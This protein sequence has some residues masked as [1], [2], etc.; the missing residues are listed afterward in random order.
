MAESVCLR[1]AKERHDNHD[2]GVGDDNVIS[3]AHYRRDTVAPRT[4]SSPAPVEGCE[5]DGDARTL[6]HVFNS[7]IDLLG[8]TDTTGR[9][10]CFN[11]EWE[12]VLG[13]G[14]EELDGR[15]VLDF[16]HADDRGEM[17]RALH[18]SGRAAEGER[19]RNRYRAKDGTYHFMEWRAVRD[20][21]VL[22][23]SARDISSCQLT[24]QKLRDSERRY[25]A[26]VEDQT[27]F[28]VRWK[29]DG[30]RTFVNE[31]YVRYFGQSREELVG[32]S[33][34]PLIKSEAEREAV[35]RRLATLTPESPIMTN[36]HRATRVDGQLRWQEWIDRG[37]FDA[38]GTL[39][40]L[41]SVGRD[42]HDRVVAE[43]KVHEQST[44]LR[45]LVED[46]PAAVAMFD[47]E[48]R[49]LAWSGRW[50]TD[51]RVPEQD[52]TGLSHYD[53]FPEIS[54][55]W[56]AIHQR[57]LAGA[58]ERRDEDSFP[59]LD[60]STDYVRWVCQPWY[61]AGDSHEI[62]GIILFTE[63]ITQKK[64]AEAALKR[65]ELELRKLETQIAQ[66]QKLEAIGRLSAGVAHDF[67]N[68][69]TVVNGYSELLMADERLDAEC[70]DLVGEISA[71]GER[72]GR[73]TAQLLAFS[74]QQV[75]R[76]EAVDL[77]SLVGNISSMLAR[78]IG[79]D[80]R[81]VTRIVPGLWPITADPGQIEQVLVNLTVNARDAMPRG[82]QLTIECNNV[83]V[84]EGQESR[85]HLEAG[86]WVR[87][88]VRDTGSGM[89]EATLERIFEPFFTTKEPGRGTGLGLATVY[90]I[91]QQSGGVIR[92]SSDLGKGSVFEIF[93]PSPIEAPR[94]AVVE[95]ITSQPR[96]NEGILVVEDDESV[97]VLIVSALRRFG[98]GVVAAESAEDALRLLPTLPLSVRLLV[99]DVV[100]P[101]M[102]GRELSERVRD[103]RPDIGVLF[104]SG[105]TDD[106]VLR[107]GIAHGDMD[108]LAKPFT[109]T[110]LA[111]RVRDLLSRNVSGSS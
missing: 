13:Y 26:V 43:Q 63:V 36:A 62:G 104:V 34:M 12:R 68:L 32:S 1:N 38:N 17:L 108:I 29:P 4:N 48:M 95:A 20:G 67:N 24:E 93:F 49:Y 51:Y 14:H 30:T 55:E 42:V 82:G 90:G 31:A 75:M 66:S 91:V 7:V 107:R 53:V 15:S 94:R 96:G 59:R 44:L 77:E 65:S 78:L 25:R 106:A 88:E 33:F 45:I 72:A 98:Y 79:E 87:L 105:Y 23:V 54:E 99:T 89:D 50:L 28:I 22:Y 92:V 18:S 111:V 41:Q 71:A 84:P 9:L 97:R 80:V 6:R 109:P 70:R 61:K 16:V 47:T 2:L 60:G 10:L 57:S 37:F 19:F 81:L 110:D 69:L 64:Q 76:E 27:E 11:A 103:R 40:E 100:M 46:T 101:G 85:A 73:L 83:D 86:A 56:K 102:S 21:D 74:R 58:I 8:I 35:R 3:L 39:V 5:P 52:L